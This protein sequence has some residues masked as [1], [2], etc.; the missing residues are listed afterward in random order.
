MD[1]LYRYRTSIC[2]ATQNPVSIMGALYRYWPSVCKSSIDVGVFV[3][4]K[5]LNIDKQ[6]TSNFLECNRTPHEWLTQNLFPATPW[7][8]EEHFIPFIKHEHLLVW[9]VLRLHLHPRCF[10]CPPTSETVLAA[11]RSV[12]R[13]KPVHSSNTLETYDRWISSNSG[14]IRGM[15]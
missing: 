8:L 13:G 1:V 2:K 6:H 12:I 9:Q 7:Q 4:E 15:I 5:E 14:N 10:P 3:L 11:S